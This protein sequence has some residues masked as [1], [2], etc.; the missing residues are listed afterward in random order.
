MPS[1]APHCTAEA[2]TIRHA[3][4]F[5]CTSFPTANPTPYRR[6]ID[7]P[8]CL[9]RL[10]LPLSCH[11][12][13]L[14][15]LTTASPTPY[16]R[17]I[18]HPSCLR[19]LRLPLSSHVNPTPHRPM[20]STPVCAHIWFHTYALCDFSRRPRTAFAPR[21]PRPSD[22]PSPASTP[23]PRITTHPCPAAVRGGGGLTLRTLS[24]HHTT[25]LVIA[26]LWGGASTTHTE[27][28]APSR[29]IFPHI[30]FLSTLDLRHRPPFR[31]AT[32]FW[33]A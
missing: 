32:R 17:R 3:M 6:R 5:H 20:S 31:C 27:P 29:L 7:H 2:L 16:R 4:H 1:T 23:A 8:S 21:P 19:R 22:Y 14:H 30:S 25:P 26:D 28:P 12:L 15:F 33:P 9:R 10:R 13:P 24:V 11:A 18:D